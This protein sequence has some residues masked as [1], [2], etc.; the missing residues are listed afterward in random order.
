MCNETFTYTLLFLQ[1][2]DVLT[3]SKF[4][5]II[6]QVNNVRSSQPS[7]ITVDNGFSSFLWY[8]DQ[9]APGCSF[10]Y[11]CDTLLTSF[12]WVMFFIRYVYKIKIKDR[13]V[14]NFPFIHNEPFCVCMYR[15]RGKECIYQNVQLTIHR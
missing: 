3:E 15:E 7:T 4:I 14:L 10:E 6:H 12:I 9:L 13:G 8:M 5:A 11:V 2:W 1:N